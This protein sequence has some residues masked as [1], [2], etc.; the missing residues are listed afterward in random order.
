MVLEVAIMVLISILLAGCS[1]YST[2]T[3][4][5]I[6]GLSYTNS[7]LAGLSPI[8]QNISTTF[9]SLKGASSLEVRTGF[10]GM[11]VRQKGVVWLCSADTNGLR[12]QIGAENDPLDLIG[13]AAH[14]KNDVLFSGLLFMVVVITFAA[15]LMLSTFP[16]W[17]EAR[18]ERTGSDVDVKPFPSR[19][20][21]Q[22]ALACCFVAAT[23]LLVSSLWQHVGAVGAAAMAD[24][25][26][27]G[28]V[29]TAIGSTAM[30]LSWI[31][32]AVAAVSTIALLVMIISIIILDKLTDE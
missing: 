18:D 5:Y 27:F 12:E 24:A 3:N 17:H 8:G 20:V 14:F 7:S 9:N 16:G 32:F 31:G 4:V 15:F 11:C 26:F 6:L 13:T 22:A 1:S 21:S 23:L 2:M 29:K 25:A 28:N 19:P 30:L 10:F